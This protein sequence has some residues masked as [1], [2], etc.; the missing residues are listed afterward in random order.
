MCF[1]A[2]AAASTCGRCWLCGVARMTASIGQDLFVGG[3]DAQAELFRDV[4]RG[5]RLQR[6]PAGDPQQL[7]AFGGPHQF[8]APPAESD[9]RNIQHRV[10]LHS[11]IRAGKRPPFVRE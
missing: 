3:P 10:F 11:F 8:L 6:D 9:R 7:A 1:P 4:A 5:L 2:A